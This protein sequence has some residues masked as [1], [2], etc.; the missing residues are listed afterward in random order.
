M[1]EVGGTGSLCN[2]NGV[3]WGGPRR[4]VTGIIAACSVTQQG[5]LEHAICMMAG[6]LGA[7]IAAMPGMDMPPGWLQHCAEGVPAQDGVH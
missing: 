5:E 2:I 3:E 1:T 7:R 4:V 6:R